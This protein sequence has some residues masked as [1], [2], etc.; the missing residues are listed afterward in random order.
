MAWHLWQELAGGQE[1]LKALRREHAVCGQILREKE[2]EVAGLIAEGTAL[3]KAQLAKDTAIKQ[4]RAELRDAETKVRARAHG[5]MG[6]RMLSGLGLRAGLTWARPCCVGA[7]GD[8]AGR[9]GR[10]GKEPRATDQ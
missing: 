10:Q 4:L 1:E 6:M 9:P 2:A 7:G 3:S 5:G 8:S